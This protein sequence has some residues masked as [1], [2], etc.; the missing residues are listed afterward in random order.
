MIQLTKILE[1]G[2]DITKGVT[3]PRYLVLSNGLREV[4]VPVSDEVVQEVASLLA[5]PEPEVVAQTFGPEETA[6]AGPPGPGPVEHIRVKP[7]LVK[8]DPVPPPSTDVE[9]DTFDPGDEYDDTGTG[10]SSL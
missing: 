5:D 3:L 8:D 4:S 2:V 6:P 1:G 10:V 7:V 9:E